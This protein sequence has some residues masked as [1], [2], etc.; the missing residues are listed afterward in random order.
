M[1]FGVITKINNHR[2]NLACVFEL[3]EQLE[4]PN[5]AN[6]Y[7]GKIE[8]VNPLICLNLREPVFHVGEV[9]ILDDNGREIPYPG[10]RPAKWDVECEKFDDVDNAIQCAVM[11]MQIARDAS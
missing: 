2:G 6:D 11:H 8:Q 7:H 1:K 3:Y 5:E 4:Q 10:R 9:L